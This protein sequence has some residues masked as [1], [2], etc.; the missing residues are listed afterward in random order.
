[1]SI[2]T[3]VAKK[4]TPAQREKARVAL[5]EGPYQ[6]VGR[7]EAAEIVGVNKSNLTKTHGFP[8]PILVLSKG[9]L[10]LRA[11]VE[12]FAVELKGRTWPRG[13]RR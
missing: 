3:G 6:L 5:H 4:V 1:V 13:G 2:K 11:E 7:K 8:E 12:Y 9:A 10:W